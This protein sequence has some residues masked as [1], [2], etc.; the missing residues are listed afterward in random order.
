MTAPATPTPV[1]AEEDWRAAVSDHLLNAAH[2]RLRPPPVTDR[3]FWEGRDPATVQAVELRARSSSGTPWPQTTATAY[4]R[5][6]RDGNRTAYE[7]AAGRL[8]A[9]TAD[10]VV[11]ALVSGGEPGWVDE[12]GDGLALLCEQSTWCWAAHEQFTASRGEVV[13][14]PGDPC[15]DLGAGETVALLAW[16]D[17]AIGSLL[18]GRLPGLRR[19]LRQEA[20]HRVIDPFL[21]RRDWHWLGLDG[22]LHNWNPWIHQNVLAAALLLVDDAATRGA[23][24]RHCLEGLDR[25]R[26]SLPSDGGCDEGAGYWWNG[27]ARLAECALLL[28]RASGGALD[29]ISSPPMDELARFP[30]RMDLGRGWRVS[31]ADCRARPDTRPPWQLVH[32]WGRLAGLDDVA[33]HAAVQRDR[34]SADVSSSEGLARLLG[35]LLDD[36]WRDASPDA[37]PD[38]WPDA[39]PLRASVWLPQTEVFVARERAA[40]V[41]GLVVAAKG[42][43]NDENHNHDDVGSYLVAL[44]SVPVLVDLGQQTYTSISFSARR[45]EQLS[46]RADWHNVPVIGETTQAHGSGYA[47]R[48]ATATSGPDRDSFTLDLAGAYPEEAGCRQWRRQV[49]LDRAARA[50][51]VRDDYVLEPAAM[52]HL[53]HVLAGEVV[54]HGEGACT[55]RSLGGGLVDLR[56]EP[57]LGAGRLERHAVDDELLRQQWGPVLHRLWID[58]P[59]AT[60]GTFSLR[61]HAHPE[62]TPHDLD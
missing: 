15:L 44:D 45:Y 57:R 11:M 24:V 36:A 41:D 49:G 26:R 47:S 25:Y 14:D 23:A 34:S 13:P 28:H 3:P 18:D 52:V 20:R 37:G 62:G 48:G 32:R 54:A 7:D 46:V 9:R 27:P 17:A 56:W 29:L 22:R 10:A 2:E 59:A 50:V 12:A 55:V 40:D 6:W 19:R 30:M 33:A 21:S 61:V 31:F 60:A 8:R 38:A 1:P 43:H 4:A 16:A 5:Y 51:L 42:G 58:L 53:P 35:S 39:T